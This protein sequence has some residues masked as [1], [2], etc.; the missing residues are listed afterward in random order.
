[1]VEE[2]C[3]HTHI[4]RHRLT[5]INTHTHTHTHTH[6][7]IYIYTHTNTHT[8]TV[9]RGLYQNALRL[10]FKRPRWY[11][12]CDAQQKSSLKPCLLGDIEGLL[13]E[14]SCLFRFLN[15]N[16]LCNCICTACVFLASMYAG[17]CVMCM[18]MLMF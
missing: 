9:A 3:L 2:T 6:I 7:Y 17:M 4:Y 10:T 12:L 18:Q 1:M 5:H 15:G 13:Q 16:K 11:D 14:N 8:Q